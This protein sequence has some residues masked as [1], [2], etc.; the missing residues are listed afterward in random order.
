M[1]HE[2]RF[3]H[4]SAISGSF[5]HMAAYFK[6]FHSN[7][8]S[9]NPGRIF[10]GMNPTIKTGDEVVF[11]SDFESG[12]LDT[13]IKVAD[14]E[15]D[16]FMR[17]D[18]NTRGHVQWF[19]FTVKNFG[20]KKIRL[21]IVNFKK[22]KTLYSRDMRPYLYSENIKQTKGFDWHQG[23]ENVKYEKKKLRYTFL[24]ENY[25]EEAITYNCLSFDY[26]F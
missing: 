1:T 11:D 4:E 24:E 9:K 6:K 19:N 18:T 21:N 13:V 26:V 7:F 23:G 17:V 5:S 16:L 12:N 2:Y 10:K 8:K 15:Y 20:K 14:N 3:K 22:Y 25:L